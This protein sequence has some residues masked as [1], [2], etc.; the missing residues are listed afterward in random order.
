MDW[1]KQEDMARLGILHEF[2]DF[3]EA[4]QWIR[5]EHKE[6]KEPRWARREMVE[7]ILLKELIRAIQ[8]GE[9][10]P[11]GH[12]NDVAEIVILKEPRSPMELDLIGL[13]RSYEMLLPND[14]E[15]T[16]VKNWPLTITALRK[17]LFGMSGRDYGLDPLR[18]AAKRMGIP[19]RD[20]RQ[21]S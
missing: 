8:T 6:E 13:K 10:S 9:K 16:I 18:K 19:I 1:K 5:E 2:H 4:V 14:P 21:K 20:K 3:A 17:I 7:S 12:L 15:H 11:L